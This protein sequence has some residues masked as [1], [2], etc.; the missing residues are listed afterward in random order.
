MKYLH[1]TKNALYLHKKDAAM[2]YAQELVTAP[3]LVSIL[4][5]LLYDTERRSELENNIS[6]LMP[7]DAAEN[8]CKIIL[9]LCQKN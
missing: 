9:N 1:L 5:E 8:V 4:T 2:V 7:R 6:R 3:R